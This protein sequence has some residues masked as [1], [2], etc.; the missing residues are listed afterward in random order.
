MQWGQKNP[1]Q[2]AP[3]PFIYALPNLGGTCPF[4]YSDAVLC[5]L[6]PGAGDS[7]SNAPDPSN[8]NLDPDQHHHHHHHRCRHSPP[9]TSFCCHH[10]H[11]DC[12][13]TE[14]SEAPAAPTA[15][16]EGAPLDTEP[17]SSPLPAPDESHS[18]QSSQDDIST[19]SSTEL[20][21]RSEPG[22]R[23]QQEPQAGDSEPASEATTPTQRD[24][25]TSPTTSGFS[26]SEGLS[27]EGGVGDDEK[28]KRSQKK[29]SDTVKRKR[30][31]NRRQREYGAG[32][33]PRLQHQHQHQHQPG[34]AQYDPWVYVCPQVPQIPVPMMDHHH[35]SGWHFTGPHHH[36]WPTATPITPAAPQYWMTPMVPVAGFVG[37]PV[38]CS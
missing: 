22:P 32:V 24:A 21:G 12:P 30:P 8:L 27:E 29:G 2:N 7:N 38:A 17:P 28:K 5:C 6:F 15:T 25:Q 35:H 34:G 1:F 13:P 23:Q 9:V 14:S 16:E 10:H 18:K 33:P 26:V 3:G 4:S 31:R 19:S 36:H 20:E 37:V 11:H